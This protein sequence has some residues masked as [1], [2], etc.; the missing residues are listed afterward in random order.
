M[1]RRKMSTARSC[2]PS[3]C[4]S[5]DADR[6]AVDGAVEFVQPGGELD[7]GQLLLHLAETAERREL[8]ARHLREAPEPRLNLLLRQLEIRHLLRPE[9]QHLG[10]LLGVVVAE[11]V[12]IA[13]RL[14]AGV[15]TVDA[16]HEISS[17][18][19]RGQHHADHHGDEADGDELE[20]QDAASDGHAASRVVGSAG[21]D[22]ITPWR[23]GT[24]PPRHPATRLSEF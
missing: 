18:A 13:D 5:E 14:E 2:C 1:L 15:D 19:Q 21:S 6:R 24:S 20:Q 22:T 3:A 12:E 16:A 9:Q 8:L 23:R 7:L 11:A 4:A 17:Q 10:Q